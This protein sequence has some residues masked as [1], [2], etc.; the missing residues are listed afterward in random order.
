MYRKILIG[1]DGS[2]HAKDA[3][4][5]GK[6]LREATGAELCL[7]GV[8]LFPVP[9]HP[10]PS[11]VDREARQAFAD[12]LTDAASAVGATGRPVLSTSAARGLH[13]LAEAI[14]ADLVVVG[15]SRHGTLGQALIGN[16]GIALMHGS[17]CAVGIAPAGYRDRTSG[18]ISRLVVGFDGSAESEL[19][20]EAAVPLARETGAKLTVVAVAEPPDRGTGKGDGGWRAIKEV[21][22]EQ[23]RDVLSRVVA[24]VPDDIAAEPMLISGDPAEV[25]S[26]TVDE[27]G[28]VLVVGSR[29]YGPVRRVLL[30]SVSRVLARSAPAPMIVHPRSMHERAGEPESAYAHT[31]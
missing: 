3:L 8:L 10:T 14:E 27:P 2:D 4:T 28:T 16:V 7:G 31:A 13:E 26:E 5:L 15:S 9:T 20:L 1:Y 11:P 29:A 24:S 18:T 19:A 25:L 30:G 22:E 12:S 17:P 21:I 23:T 6:E